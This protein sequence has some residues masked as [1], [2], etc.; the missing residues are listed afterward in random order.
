VVFGASV[1]RSVEQHT[2]AALRTRTTPCRT[3]LPC[4]VREVNGPAGLQA[5]LPPGWRVVCF[6]TRAYAQ[7]LGW[8]VREAAG[9][10]LQCQELRT[11]SQEDNPAVA[12][13][14]R[15]G[16]EPVANVAVAATPLGPAGSRTLALLN[17]P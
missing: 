6:T 9:L 5:V 13:P 15:R 16:L 14:V 11:L 12:R 2:S 17:V 3:F 10:Q 4:A 7:N 1:L 8:A